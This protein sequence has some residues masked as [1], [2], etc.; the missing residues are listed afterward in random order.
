MPGN[1]HTSPPRL[2][3]SAINRLT[4][5]AF[6]ASDNGSEAININPAENESALLGIGSASLETESPA[7]LE[8]ASPTRLA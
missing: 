8:T 4:A 6:S 2:A 3:C 5:S 1:S 7:S